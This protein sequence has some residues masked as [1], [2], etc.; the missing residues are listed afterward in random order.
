MCQSEESHKQSDFAKEPEVAGALRKV[1]QNRRLTKEF[2]ETDEF[3][4]IL[5]SLRKTILDGSPYEVWSCLSIAGRAASVSKPME[6]VFLT[7]VEERIASGLPSFEALQ[8]GEDRWYLAKA[9]Q[10]KTT[11]EVV[12]IAFSEIVRDDLGEKARRVWVEIGLSAAETREEFLN[13]INRNIDSLL[14]SEGVRSDLLTRRIRRINSAID[15]RLIT[16]DLPSGSEFSH[17]LRLFFTGHLPKEG[18]EDRRLREEAAIEVI[19]SLIDIVRLS[20]S[21]SSDPKSYLIAQDLRNWWQPA[22]PPQEFEGLSRR[23]IRHGAEALHVFSR[24]GLRNEALRNSLKAVGGSDLLAGITR[25]IVN[26]DSSLPEEMS[27]WFCTGEEPRKRQSSAAVTALSGER[28]DTDISRLLIY[29]SSAEFDGAA[30]ERIAQD[31]SELMPDEGQIISRTSGRA[32]QVSQ[33]VQSLAKRR[34]INLFLDI[35]EVVQ[36]D[37]AQHEAVN[38]G[39]IAAT[40]LVVRPGTRKTEPSRSPYILL[41]PKVKHS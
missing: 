30:I 25:T 22:S 34:H 4:E 33:V 41:K 12:E 23:L 28:L 38:E 1:I 16:S 21:A 32:K 6:A 10:R 31:V 7:I 26:R 27:A 15:D 8:D 18:P 3:E 14:S 9:M 11:P 5:V 39:P 2:L 20:L 36:F 17:Q 29:V 19:G 40:V 24:Q 37:P 13:K 35:G